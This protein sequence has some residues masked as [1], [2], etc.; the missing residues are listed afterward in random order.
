MTTTTRSAR[1]SL[2]ASLCALAFAACASSTPQT[3]TLADAIGTWQLDATIPAGGR[4]PTMTIGKD[5]SVHGNG[6]VNR[7][8]ATL[9]TNGLRQGRWRMSAAQST[10]MAGPQEAMALEQ[11]LLDA[12]QQADA[13]QIEDGRL[14]LLRDGKRLVRFLRPSF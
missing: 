12:L 6:G 14:C 3:A 10:R 11:T 9:D 13:A 8:A 7:Y 2:R 4:I 5:G 1:F